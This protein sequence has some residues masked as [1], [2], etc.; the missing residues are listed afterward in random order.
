MVNHKLL[1]FG[2][3]LTSEFHMRFTV[4][5]L[6]YH[7]GNF[8]ANKEKICKAIKKARDEN[9]DLIVFSELSVPGYPPLDL[10]DRYDFVEKCSKTVHE[11]A[12][13]CKGITAIVGS[14]VVN[15]NPE[16]KSCSTLLLSSQRGRSSF[17][18]TKHFCR[19]MTFLTN[20]GI[21]QPD[22]SFTVFPFKGFRVA[23]T[24]C[25]DIWDEQPFDNEFEKKRLYTV[26]PMDELA[27]RIL[28]FI[29]NI[30]ASPFSY[31]KIDVKT[32]VFRNKAAKHGIRLSV[33]T[34]QVQTP[35]LSSMEHR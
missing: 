11:I 18:P 34:R 27:G 30:S 6:N 4:A 10:L 17:R 31:T 29:I 35:N 32:S 21:F 24:I 3:A 5:Q 8:T 20:T 13:E 16:G 14:P 23:L 22:R 2:W 26:S 9:S 1:S 15:T 28:I 12:R 33:Q 7:I 19:L 25:E